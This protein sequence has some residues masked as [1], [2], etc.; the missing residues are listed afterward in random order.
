MFFFF[1]FQAED[2]IRD[3]CV[4]GV[5][6]CAL[7]ISAADRGAGCRPG[8]SARGWGRRRRP[9][10]SGAPDRRAGCRDAGPGRSS[11]AARRGPRAGPRGGA[12]SARCGR[13]ADRR[14]PSPPAPRRS[15]KRRTRAAPPRPGPSW[16]AAATGASARHSPQAS[17]A[18]A[19]GP[20]PTAA[21]ARPTCPSGACAAAPR[22]RRHGT[23]S[24]RRQTA[25]SSA[26][27]P[28]AADRDSAGGSRRSAALGRRRAAPWSAAP[29]SC[30]RGRRPWRPPTTATAPTSRRTPAR[31]PLRRTARGTR[32][33]P[34]PQPGRP[35]PRSPPDTRARAAADRSRSATS[36]AAGHGQRSPTARPATD[37]P[38]PPHPRATGTRAPAKWP[39]SRSSARHP[40]EPRD[41]RR[42]APP[43]L[44]RAPDGSRHE[45][46]RQRVDLRLDRL[47]GRQIL[48]R[49]PVV[50]ELQ[51]D[52]RRLDRGVPRLRLHRLKRHPLLAQPRQTRVPQLMA[53]QPLQTGSPPR[54]VQ[55]LIEARRRQ[56][57]TAP[58]ALQHHEARLRRRVRRPLDL[59]ILA[60]RLKEPPRH[61][62]DPLA[63]PHAVGDEQAPLPGVDIAEPQPQHLA[64]AQPAEQHRQHHRPVAPGPQRAKQRVDVGGREHPRQR[65]RRAHQPHTTPPPTTRPAARQPTRHRIAHHPGIPP[66]EQKRKQA[67]HAREPPGDRAR[68]QP[69]LA[70]LDPDHPLAEPGPALLGQE[71]EHVRGRHIRRLLA[72]NLEEH[73]QVVRRR[74]PRV[75][76]PA[77]ADEL[78]IAIQ[79]R[80]PEPDR[81][82]LTVLNRPPQARHEPHRTSPPLT[83][84][85]RKI[86]G[87]PDGA[88]AVGAPLRPPTAASATRP[89]HS[90]TMRLS[91][92]ATRARRRTPDHP[93]IQHADVRSTQPYLHADL[94]IKERAL[95]LVAPAEVRPGRYKPPDAVL[96][97]LEAL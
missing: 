81:A 52:A 80:M 68:R 51:I 37:P 77:R 94:T 85:A 18:A 96:A 89:P 78:Q 49:Q 66:G 48:A 56:R 14:P 64:A 16:P 87:N 1:F 79:K 97:F 40:P 24:P 19:A 45:L 60:D 70:I 72:N 75:R 32:D 15:A 44:G 41:T 86:A 95:A 88:P 42:P 7:P 12:Y 17:P 31:P 67:R 82:K 28:A 4:T 21:P 63:A 54:P 20:P 65:P 47:R 35:E 9:T 27:A 62:H 92:P 50:R 26:A 34:T 2:G 43:P 58:S 46:S 91:R 30:P 71:R 3:H 22:S 55:H 6:T 83:G 5:Q 11:T 57:P 38:I 33:K 29:A 73:L 74:Q 90:Q 13:G 39:P 61:R 59:E 25:W 8:T 23:G 10:R 84:T 53:G 76:R 93:H 69:R 36:P